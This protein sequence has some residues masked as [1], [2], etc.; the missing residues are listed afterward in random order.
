MQHPLKYVLALLAVAALAGCAATPD[1]PTY[2]GDIRAAVMQK[3]EVVKKAGAAAG[4]YARRSLSSP[5]P[6][7]NPE[8][9]GTTPPAG[10]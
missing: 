10:S 8:R 5:M 1:T 3:V 4:A 9:S 7:W 2:S 6:E